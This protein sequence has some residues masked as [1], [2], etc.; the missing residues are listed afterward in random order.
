MPK[1]MI[2]EL[3]RILH[4]F[5]HMTQRDKYADI[6]VSQRVYET[7]LKNAEFYNKILDTEEIKILSDNLNGKSYI[8]TKINH[9]ENKPK[10]N[11]E[12]FD[13]IKNIENTLLSNL[14]DLS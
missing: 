3:I 12:Y 1:E 2:K 5:C 8:A 6:D 7:Y 9:I 14:E 10:F 13:K 4:N 11:Q